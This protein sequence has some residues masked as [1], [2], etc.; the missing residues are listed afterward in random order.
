MAAIFAVGAASEVTKQRAQPLQ[1]ILI[2]RSIKVDSASGAQKADIIMLSASDVATRNSIVPLFIKEAA[3]TT[4][5]SSLAAPDAAQL[6]NLLGNTI[7]TFNDYDRN[8]ILK[9]LHV[10]KCE[11]L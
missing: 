11:Y 10:K 1:S 6:Q 4:A 5:G 9:Y 2:V 3:A 7:A 8:D